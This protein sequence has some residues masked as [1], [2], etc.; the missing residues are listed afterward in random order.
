MAIIDRVKN[1]CLSPATEWPVIAAESASTGSLISGYVAPLAAIGAVAGF[2]GGSIIGY[3]GFGVTVRTPFVSGLGGAIFSFAIVIV[4]V[5]LLGLLVD[6]LA[7]TFGGQK[8]SIQ[9]FKV[10]AYSVTP[11]LVAGVLGLIPSVALAGLSALIAL[12]GLYL[13][14]LGLP[15]LMKA[16]KEKAVGYTA[17]VVVVAFVAGIVVN[18]LLFAV[19]GLRLMGGAA[20]AGGPFGT[21]SAGST[22]EV[23]FDKDSTLG[24]LEEF[25][26]RM[27]EQ[28]KKM[29]AA[30]KSGD[31]AAQANAAAETLGALFGGGRRV[32]PI[33][34][35]QLKTFVPD[36]FAG[37]P[38]TRFQSEKNGMAGLMISNAEATYSDGA[39][40][41]VELQVSDPGGASGLVG[42][43][44]WA[45]VQSTRED[46]N[47]SERTTKVDGRMVHEKTTKAG[48][49]EFS[50]VLG[51]RF[52]VSAKSSGVPL[53]DLKAAVG[54]LDLAKLE[55]MKDV[56]VK[57]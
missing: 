25:G 52:V 20:M 19:L 1:I 14:Y 37:M 40:K 27:E 15:V 5:F 31:A 28:G 32:E 53:S 23:T 12:Y 29:E 16:P 44:S 35:D 41:R 43:A 26:K 57:K 3:S 11:G 46:E 56:G 34:P 30:E 4:A 50:V 42:L 39:G 55:G 48:D 7:P 17:T 21:S 13:L 49:D 9:A 8:S 6:A 33:E 2:I 24:K 18:T 36:T 38:R 47:G 51:E 45:N 22:A 10:A 54:K